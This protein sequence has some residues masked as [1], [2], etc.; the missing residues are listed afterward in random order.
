VKLRLVTNSISHRLSLLEKGCFLNERNLVVSTEGEYISPTQRV[1]DTTLLGY[2]YV[3]VQCLLAHAINIPVPTVGLNQLNYG[4]SVTL[5][6]DIYQLFE[7]ITWAERIKKQ[8][9][10]LPK[11][12]SSEINGQISSHIANSDNPKEYFPIHNFPKDA[13]FVIRNTELEK[14]FS[15]P[16][17]CESR[18]KKPTRISTPL[19]RMFWLA[20][21]HNETISPLIKKPYKLLSIF[22]QWASAEGITDRL[23]GDTLKNALER[24]SPTSISAS[25]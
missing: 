11:D 6:G 7:K 4:I 17:K 3:L 13:C 14:L 15:T 2:E 21:K 16:E 20:C 22:E 25:H 8:L 10:R 9:M 1:I 19:S 12:I 18:L 5:S 24:G 23:S